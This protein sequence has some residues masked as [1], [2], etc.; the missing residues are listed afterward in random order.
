MKKKTTSKK[1]D[2]LKEILN[3]LKKLNE[4]IEKLES[5]SQQPV[6]VYPFYQPPY[7]IQPL[8]LPLPLPQPYIPCQPIW[9]KIPEIICDSPNITVDTKSPN[10]TEIRVGDPY[11]ST[12]AT[13]IT[14]QNPPIVTYTCC[15]QETLSNLPEFS[16]CPGCGNLNS[17][18]QISFKVIS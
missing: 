10:I 15:D 12:T 9:W 11:P 3:E 17:N 7:I 18:S 8:P 4:K 2:L 13:N 1:Q 5:R 14:D 6:Y 16:G